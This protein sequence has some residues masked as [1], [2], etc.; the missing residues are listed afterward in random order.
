MKLDW[1]SGVQIKGWD[2]PVRQFK[3]R[4]ICMYLHMN[5]VRLRN[6]LTFL[7]LVRGFNFINASVLSTNDRMKFHLL[8][9][10][11]NEFAL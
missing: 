10:L 6:C 8:D 2:F 3:G 4:A 7:M 9:D 1:Q 11:D 5:L